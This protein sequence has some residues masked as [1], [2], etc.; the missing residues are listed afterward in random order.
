[1]RASGDVNVKETAGDLWLGAALS[2]GGVLRLWAPGGAIR[3][4]IPD[5]TNPYWNL[6]GTQIYLS[7]ISLGTADN[8]LDFEQI[9]SAPDTALRIPSR[10]RC[11]K[12]R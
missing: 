9:Y 11:L 5:A 1:M 3:D 12:A 10:L 4:S 2:A 6:Y 8:R 7:A